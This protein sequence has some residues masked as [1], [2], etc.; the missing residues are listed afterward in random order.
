[1]DH[2][3][4]EVSDTPTRQYVQ[5]KSAKKMRSRE[6]ISITHPEKQSTLLQRIVVRMYFG[7][8]Q[9]LS[10]KLV[11]WTSKKQNNVSNSTTKE[12][13]VVATNCCCF[14]GRGIPDHIGP[15]LILGNFWAEARL[16]KHAARGRSPRTS[17][18]RPPGF[19]LGFTTMQC[20]SLTTRLTLLWLQPIVV[21]MSVTM[22]TSIPVQHSRTKHIY[23]R[24]HFI[25]DHVEKSNIDML[26]IQKD[27]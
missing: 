10:D 6:V 15:R 13:Y 12:E 9:F 4:D 22:I 21:R 27:F 19:E 25:K 20:P 5:M 7:S 17:R 1:M 8:C 2:V 16:L 26:F 3:R 24:H 23:I 18:M 11:N 14:F